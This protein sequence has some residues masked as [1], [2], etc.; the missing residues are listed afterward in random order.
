MRAS[1]R[2]VPFLVFR[3]LLAD[4]H[5][6]I[7]LIRFGAEAAD[8]YDALSVRGDEAAT[9]AFLEQLARGGPALELAIGTG[10]IA[11]PLAARGITVDGIDLSVAPSSNAGS[12]PTSERIQSRKAPILGDRRRAS[13]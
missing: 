6:D 11:L 9:I 8:H 5:D 4:H 3:H 12:A 2:A 10:R 13:G 1:C 7:A